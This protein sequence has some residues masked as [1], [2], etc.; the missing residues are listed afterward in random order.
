MPKG[1]PAAP[2]VQANLHHQVQIKRLG[3]WVYLSG[4]LTEAAA[5]KAMKR[6]QKWTTEEVR[7]SSRH[8]PDFLD[9]EDHR[10]FSRSR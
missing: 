1:H 6:A 2:L 3:V 10:S 5:F 7:V 9:V 8:D 4:H